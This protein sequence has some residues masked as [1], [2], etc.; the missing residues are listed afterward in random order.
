[1]NPIKQHKKLAKLNLKASDC[2]T[3]EEAQILIRKAEKV[4]RKLCKAFGEHHQPG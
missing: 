3:R 2:L 4:H 1:M